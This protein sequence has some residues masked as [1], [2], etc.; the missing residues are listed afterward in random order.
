MDNALIYY[1]VIGIVSVLGISLITYFVFVYRDLSLGTW[2]LYIFLIIPGYMILAQ[3]F[4]YYSLHFYAD[5]A[6]WFEIIC[7]ISSIGKP[8]SLTQD[9]YIPGTENYFSVHF[10][11]LIYLLAAPFKIWPYGE[12]IIVLNF[13]LMISSAIPLYKLSQS[14]NKDKRFALFMVVVLLWYPTFQYTVLYEFE[15]LRFSI[16]I[17]LWMLYFWQKRNMFAY[18]FFAVLAVLVREEVGLTIMMFGFYLIFV[19]KQR[20][21]GIISALIG[22]VAFCLI[23]GVIM[24]ALRVG[25][26]DQHIAM[27]VFSTF[28]SSFWEILLNMVG[29]PA[30]VI[31]TIF[32]PVR[33]ANVFMFFL[34]LLCIP[35]LAPTVLIVIIANFGIVLLTT[36][37][38]NSSYML[39]YLSPSIPFIFYAFIRAWPRFL[40]LLEALTPKSYI[41]RVT[42]LNYAAMVTVLSGLLVA[43]VFFGPSPLSLQFWFKDLRPAPFQTQDFHYSV[44]KITNH[45][46]KVEEFIRVIPDSAIVS[47]Q[48][49]LF[50]R[51]AKKGGAMMFPKVENKDGLIKAEY[52]LFDK[53]N[54]GIKEASPAYIVSSDFDLIEKNPVSWKLVRSGDSYYLYKNK[55]LTTSEKQ[56]RK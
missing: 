4:K 38:T 24:P 45:H 42:D 11:P 10:V 9:I 18:Y 25:V 23:I 16:P 33:L 19:E 26:E 35:F 3:L 37:I 41:R 12:T 43:N 56:L 32:Q 34:P 49:F 47:S 17:I 40:R 48:Q 2:I 30:L 36:S 44:Y 54:N 5:F 21:T 13:L 50:P 6:H 39:Y 7:N 1:Y 29:N 8:L 20:R 55:L 22:F 27:Q 53:T 46:R 28:G 51:L 31:K 14:Y 52:V 15:M